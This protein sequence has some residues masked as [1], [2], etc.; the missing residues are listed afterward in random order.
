MTMYFV[1]K[2]GKVKKDH[3]T[4]LEHM[5][6]AMKSMLVDLNGKK[7]SR[8]QLAIEAL[9]ERCCSDDAKERDIRLMLD[10]LGETPNENTGKGNQVPQIIY[11]IGKIEDE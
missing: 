7:V 6:N 4:A 8:L 2:Y 3:R 11:N 1:D 10:I 5:D 9:A